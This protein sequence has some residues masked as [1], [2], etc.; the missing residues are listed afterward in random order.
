MDKI[1]PGLDDVIVSLY[2]HLIINL[3]SGNSSCGVLCKLVLYHRQHVVA[4]SIIRTGW[5]VWVQLNRAVVLGTL[6]RFFNSTKQDPKDLAA[7]INSI[8]KWLKMKEK[9][10]FTLPPD[11]I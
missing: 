4:S 1:L 7:L 2:Y 6:L 9:I 8:L 11:N 5:S 3:A 10:E